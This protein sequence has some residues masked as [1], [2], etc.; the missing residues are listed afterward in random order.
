MAQALLSSSEAHPD[1]NKKAQYATHKGMA[2]KAYPGQGAWHGYPVGWNEVPPTICTKWL[3]EGL[4][5][6]GDVRRYASLKT[7]EKG[8]IAG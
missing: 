8:H 2:F 5:Q 6:R 3:R 4:I 7:D 1:A